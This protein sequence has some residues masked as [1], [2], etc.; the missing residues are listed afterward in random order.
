[1]SCMTRAN[2]WLSFTSVVVLAPPVI[3]LVRFKHGSA[4]LA[5][6]AL[7]SPS[8]LQPCR[9]AR[10][11]MSSCLGCTSMLLEVDSVVGT[12]A[13]VYLKVRHHQGL[14]AGG[15]GESARRVPTSEVVLRFPSVSQVSP[16]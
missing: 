2:R 13:E 1:V 16:P 14:K 6:E 15:V 9:A 12:R 11:C 8:M 10:L 3:M 4:W 5:L 7:I